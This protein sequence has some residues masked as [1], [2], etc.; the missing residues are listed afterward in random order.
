[1]IHLKSVVAPLIG[2]RG[3]P[4]PAAPWS[5]LGLRTLGPRPILTVTGRYFCARPHPGELPYQLPHWLRS[6]PTNHNGLARPIHRPYR[7]RTGRQLP[8]AWLGQSSHRPRPRKPVKPRSFGR[9][10]FVTGPRSALLFRP[11]CPSLA[12][13]PCQLVSRPAPNSSPVAPAWSGAARF[14]STK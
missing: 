5:R 4:A 7:R 8:A 13:P 2:P 14:P 6:H 12:P 11:Q 10:P 3:R 1:K 9:E